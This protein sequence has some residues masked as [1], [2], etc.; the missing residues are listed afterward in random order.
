MIFLTSL[1]VV[2]IGFKQNFKWKIE[3][4]NSENKTEISE[5]QKG[6]D[7]QTSA[8]KTPAHSLAF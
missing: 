7:P 6:S 1:N 4:A 5:S 2:G 3:L 8:R